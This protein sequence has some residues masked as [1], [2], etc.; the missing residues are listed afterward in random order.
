MSITTTP[1]RFTSAAE[2]SSSDPV[3]ISLI[4]PCS[5]EGPGIQYFPAGKARIQSQAGKG[6]K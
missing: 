4:S 6:Q 1:G 3:S 5:T 2:G